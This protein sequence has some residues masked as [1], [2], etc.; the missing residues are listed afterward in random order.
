MES[1][2]REYDVFITTQ[3]DKIYIGN[4][5]ATSVKQAKM[6]ALALNS[7]Q[8]IIKMLLETNKDYSVIAEISSTFPIYK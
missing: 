4:I 3:S 8:P 2:I 6:K 5:F 7:T 1:S